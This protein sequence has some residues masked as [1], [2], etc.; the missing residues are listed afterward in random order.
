MRSLVF[1]TALIMSS[2]IAMAGKTK[3][4][5]PK[6]ALL[7][8]LPIFGDCPAEL[9]LPWAGLVAESL[10]LILP[11]VNLKVIAK[12]PTEPILP[13]AVEPIARQAG[14][15]I[16]ASAVVWGELIPP[17]DCLA[18]RVI[19]L[20]ILDL[21]T[22][23][24]IRRE[25]C[26]SQVSA[27]DLARVVALA[28]SNALKDGAVE[29]IHVPIS[30]SKRIEKK[31]ARH[32]DRKICNENKPCICPPEKADCNHSYGSRLNILVGGFFSSHPN[33]INSGLG[34]E[35]GLEWSATDW[36]GIGLTLAAVRGRRIDVGDVNALFTSWPVSVYGKFFWG[37][38]SAK[39]GLVLGGELALSR[40]DVLIERLDSVKSVDRV[41]PVVFAGLAL[42]IRMG[43]MVLLELDAGP[44]VF[45]RR[46]KYN[47]TTPEGSKTVLQMQSISL[48]AGLNLLINIF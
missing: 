6:D 32:V 24:L 7:L 36:F 1:I 3:T 26:P 10:L 4:R 35:A 2:N 29:G 25:I 31:K 42:R 5:R 21:K 17:R 46:Q 27:E 48:E 45:L 12:Q 33:W 14:D 11:Q 40:L 38:E 44:A 28:V 15:E 43:E 30:K 19:R 18:S 8:V 47:Y 41:N 16:G 13:G 20:W 23:G 22:Q 39:W 34:L 37:N 9:Q